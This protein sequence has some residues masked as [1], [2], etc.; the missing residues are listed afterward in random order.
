MDAISLISQD[1]F[2]KVRS[3]FSNLEMGDENGNVTS[4]PRNARFFDFDF[5]MEG[6]N[7]G[8]VSISINERG[9]LKMFYGQGILEGHDPIT[10]DIWFRFLKEM[11]M[12]AKRRLL[13]FDTRDITKSNLNK[14]DFQYLASTGSKEDNMTESKMFGSARTSYLPLDKTRLIIRHS[15]PVNSR[16][17]GARSRNISSIYI[18]NADGERF[19]YP[20]IHKA[21]AEAMQRHVANGGRPH[22]DHGRAIIAMSEQ[23]AQL[24]AFKKHVGH[25]DSMQT[26]ANEIIDRAS[27]KLESLR[28]QIKNLSKQ[29]HYEEW[30]AGI[31]S[32]SAED[33]MIMDQATMEDYK[34]KF[35][36]NTFSEDLTQYF[37]LIHKIMQEAGTIELDQYVQETKCDCEKCKKCKECLEDCSCED[38]PVKEFAEFESWMSKVAEGHLP[39]DVLTK[40][41]DL[42]DNGDI[43]AGVDGVNAIQSLEG[44]GINDEELNDLIKKS[45][46]N[47]DLTTVVTL[48]LTNKGD[49][50]SIKELG[51]HQTIDTETEPKDEPEIDSPPDGEEEPVSGEEEPVPGENPNP[52]F[53][54]GTEPASP[55]EEDE[56]D[57]ERSAGKEKG[58]NKK[59]SLKEIAEMVKSFYDRKTGRFP[60]GETGVVTKITKDLGE[61]A[62]KLAERLVKQLSVRLNPDH[63]RADQQTFEDILKLSGIK[64]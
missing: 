63:H 28:Q 23:I 12:F 43:K 52:G 6:N 25:H 7:L 2:D 34:N 4:D 20:Y 22:D 11:R 15:S 16:V 38:K 41:K 55:S 40:L 44:I 14:E 19:K 54:P 13:R 56:E 36:I 39:E 21:G 33:E 42:L 48:W 31:G 18:E 3:R 46:P 10:Q 9:T 61:W 1:L 30:K 53:E 62:G 64:K 35:T 47:G 29:H 50:D 45:G 60:L 32:S 8:R 5:T 59:P 27:A 58:K 57:L 49:T 26:G 51:L 37:P 24:H 17:P